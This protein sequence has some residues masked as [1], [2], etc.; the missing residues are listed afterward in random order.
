MSPGEAPGLTPADKRQALDLVLGSRTLA[1]CDRLKDL[2]QFV[3]QVASPFLNNIP[4]IRA[5]LGRIQTECNTPQPVPSEQRTERAK[6]LRTSCH[7]LLDT[8]ENG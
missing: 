7:I 3:S 8:P 2:L 4:R 6:K 1:R 5:R